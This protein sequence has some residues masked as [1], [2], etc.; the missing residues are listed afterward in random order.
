MH[1]S[2]PPQIT[3]QQKTSLEKAALDLFIC[4]GVLMLEIVSGRRNNSFE[5]VDDALN[6][7]GYAWD[8]WQ[9]GE[10]IE[11]VD[12]AIS[13]SCVKYQLLRCIHVSLL[14]VEDG[15]IDRPTMSDVLFLLTNES[16]P[17]PL[18]KKPAFSIGRK[19]IEANI[20]DKE[21]NN[22]SLN[23]LSIS[24]MDAR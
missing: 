9:K 20:S 23:G 7:V 15:A 21:S 6:L 2:R 14:C 10:G 22:H 19:A 4:F 8:L 16:M 24:E 17:L 18:P 11:L 12:P 3:S 5:H 13:D 1:A